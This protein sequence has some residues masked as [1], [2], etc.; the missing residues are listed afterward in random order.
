M[1]RYRNLIKICL[2]WVIA[3]VLFGAVNV[4]VSPV[5][6]EW[7][8][9]NTTHGFYEEPENTIETIFLGSSVVVNGMIPMELY[10]TYG[11]SSYNLGT[12]QQPMLASYY[13]L[14]EAYRLHPDT[15]DTLVLEVSM[16]RRTPEDAFFHKALDGMQLSR[17][18]CR[19]LA[20]YTDDFREIISDLIPVLSYHDRWKSLADSDFSKLNCEMELYTRG[21]NYNGERYISYIEDVDL[22]AQPPYLE[23]EGVRETSLDYNSLLYLKRM[24]QFCASHEIRLVLMKAPIFS[25]AYWSAGW[26]TADHKAVKQIAEEYHLDFFDFNFWPYIDEIAYSNAT[27][28]FDG[29]HLNY[30]GA[31]KLTSW[32]GRYLIRSCGNRDVRGEERYAFLE[33]ELAQYKRS[34]VG[35]GLG[36]ITDPVAYLSYFADKEEYTVFVSVMDEASASLTARQR[37]QFTDLG[38]EQLSGLAYRDAYLGIINNNTIEIDEVKRYNEEKI[39]EESEEVSEQYEINDLEHIEELIALEETKKDAAEDAAEA[40]QLS[41]EDTLP[42]TVEGRLPDGKEYKLSSGGFASGYVASCEIDGVEYAPNQ[43][44]LN[45]VVYDHVLKKVVDTAVFDTFASPVRESKIIEES[46]DQALAE[47][48]TFSELSPLE[49]QLWLYNQACEERRSALLQSLATVG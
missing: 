42:L 36:R 24:M 37:E 3:V 7:N 18:K 9:Y 35:A 6:L 31:R 4:I 48:K 44:G 30:S 33:E 45:I 22:I 10:E 11:I 20:D 15:L 23:N 39:L 43:R 14:E 41:Q 8:N 49:Q 21:Y 25:D 34:I 26:T 29:Y 38:L 28:T 27:D 1:I 2:F 12:E 40:E 5:W 32:F 19:A 13:W 17:V 16:L 47:G 46:L